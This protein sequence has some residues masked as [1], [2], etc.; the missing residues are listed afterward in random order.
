MKHIKDVTEQTFAIEVIERSKVVPVIVDFWATWCEPCKQLTPM[1]ERAAEQYKGAFE[2]A[3]IDVD[4]NQ[5]LSKELQIQSV[6]TVAAF[7][8]GKPVPGFQGAIPEAEL[9]TWL[10]GFI[11]P[12]TNPDVELALMMLDQG[13][14][15]GA[16]AK[17]TEILSSDFNA[18]AA[19]V[20]AVLY[21]DQKRFSAAEAVLELMSNS[22]EVEQLRATVKIASAGEQAGE[23][24]AQLKADP[25]SRTLQIDYARALAGRGDYT[26]ALGGLLIM[27]EDKIEEADRAREAILD[28]FRALG[29][30]SEITQTYRRRL[31]NALY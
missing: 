22:P 12:L 31:A 18:E 26:E 5:N 2:L 27:V 15:A 17:L 29:P 6:P 10:S 16:E 24:E 21:I 4:A 19:Q 7:V 1:L 23:L 3:K 30:D 11:A 8:D 14:E 28:I 25:D 13:D 9:H 20:L